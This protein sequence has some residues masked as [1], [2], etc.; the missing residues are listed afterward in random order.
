MRH[1]RVSDN[2]KLSRAD[3]SDGS[4]STNAAPAA[5]TATCAHAH[6]K[7]L[8]QTAQERVSA[9]AT[10]RCTSSGRLDH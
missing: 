10:T 8:T 4:S 6:H 5:S 7:P 3:G 2:W 9:S 1:A